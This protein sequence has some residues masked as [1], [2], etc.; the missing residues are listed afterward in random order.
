MSNVNGQG[1]Q[2]VYLHQEEMMLIRDLIDYHPIDE[3]TQ[4]LGCT[5]SQIKHLLRKL[6]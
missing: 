5:E 6:V 3:L 2:T 4:A 1:E